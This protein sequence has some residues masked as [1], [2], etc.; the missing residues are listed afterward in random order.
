M[1]KGVGTDIVDIFRIRKIIK[2]YGLNFLEKVF[3]PSEILFCNR[4]AVPEIHFAGR[5]AA[6]EAFYK[7]LPRICQKY[8]FWHSIEVLPFDTSRSPEIT[9]LSS[10]LKSAMEKEQLSSCHV[11]ISHEKKYCIA[12][13]VLE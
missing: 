5:W 7:A 9:I 8:S 12:F 3:T 4:M 13:I 11:S 10:D 1:V 6:K 2:K